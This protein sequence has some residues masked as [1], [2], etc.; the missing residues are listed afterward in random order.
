MKHTLSTILTLICLAGFPLQAMDISFSGQL[1]NFAF[2]DGGNLAPGTVKTGLAFAVSEQIQE[3]ING[4]IYFERDPVNG[5]TL[6][7]RAA[8]HT[9]FLEISAGPSFGVL[10]ASGESK[11]VRV[12]LQ[13]GLGIGFSLTAPGIIV[14]KVDTDF[15]LPP[16]SVSSGHV[17]LQKSSLSVAFYL[18]NV[19]CSIA[20]NQRTNTLASLTDSR[21][22]SIT[23]YGFY[24]ESFRKGSLFRIGVNF[25]YRVSDYYVAPG[26]AENKK[27]GNLVLGG[28]L[29]W[30]PKTDFNVFLDGS[31]SLYAFSLEEKVNH[32]DKLYFDL[33][34]GARITIGKK[35]ENR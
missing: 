20:I 34:A 27:I 6:G 29:T 35:A 23:D 13:P 3:Q 10:N 17:Y 26:S 22:K 5:N 7:A 19:L 16:A 31:G 12:L 9:T 1:S 33:R 30:A 15:A 18:P 4:T 8:Y 2:T 32:L 25:I 11:D 21:L 24:T 28:G 14:A